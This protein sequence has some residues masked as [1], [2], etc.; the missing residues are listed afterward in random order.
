VAVWYTCLTRG[1]SGRALRIGWI[2][3]GA[4]GVGALTLGTLALVTDATSIAA[5]A[6]LASQARFI[7][8]E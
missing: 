7:G 1:S 8:H 3:A 2:A 4:L 6:K 5:A